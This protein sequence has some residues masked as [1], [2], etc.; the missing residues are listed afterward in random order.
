M[1]FCSC[2]PRTAKITGD[3][4]KAQNRFP[5]RAR[6][7]GAW[8]AAISG[9]AQSRTRLKQLGSS[10]K[11]ETKF[12]EKESRLMVARGLGHG[13]RIGSDH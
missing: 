6:D 4:R 3:I 10:S 5:T 7:G 13:G 11:A 8:W 1:E 12:I 2:K 9:V